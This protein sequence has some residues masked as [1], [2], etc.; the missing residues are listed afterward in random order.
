M[1]T[2]SSRAR[3]GAIVH[4]QAFILFLLIVAVTLAITYFAARRTR[5][6]SDFY[7][8]GGGLSPAQNALAIT[9]DYVSAASFLGIPGLI[10][11]NGFDGFFYCIGFLVAYLVV[12]YL[13]A[14]PLRN[15]G[16]YTVA[17]M[18]ASRFGD[19]RVRSIAAV[20]TVAISIFY[21]IAQMVGAGALIKLLLGLEYW[22]AVLIVGSLM[23]VYVVFGGM[24]ATSWVQITKAVLLICGTVLISLMVLAR[25]HWSLTGMFETMRTATPL[26]EK[27]LLPGNKFKDPLDTISLNLGLFFGTAGLPHILTRF[28]TVKDA[29]AARKSVVLATV[30]IG[31]FY[32]MTIFLGFGAAAFVGHDAIEKANK[33]GNM[34]APLLAKSLGGDFLFAFVSAVAFATII[35]VVAGLVL[36]S[37]SAFAHD[38]YSQIIRKGQATEKQQLT[39][40]RYAAIGVAVVSILI[41][42]GAEKQNVAFLVALAFTVAA[43]ANTPVIL[44]TIFWRKFTTTGAIAG[45]LTGL[46]SCLVLILLSP[47]VW[48]P[49]AGK[50]LFTG[51]ALFSLANPGI[52]SIPLGFLAAVIGSLLSAKQV[53]GAKF[54]EILVTANTG[55]RHSAA[56]TEQDML[57]H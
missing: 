8:V 51:K 12:L 29:V 49:E 15:L 24:R 43:S 34:A 40:A 22:Q 14:E 5:T 17:D 35:A 6:A 54:D 56:A 10:A 3:R 33:A 27:F 19:S 21:M 45:M 37:A 25:F 1:P 7:T 11:L 36:T 2:R 9:G 4:S 23:T 44:L 55:L 30:L 28:Y 57:V 32:A 31:L 52:V 41:A 16:K 39:A 38:I 13:V 20:N 18:I 46:I 47:S 26:G 50:A 53:D 42:L 48:N